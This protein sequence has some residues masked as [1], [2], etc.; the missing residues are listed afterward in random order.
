MTG[1]V[2]GTNT[3]GKLYQELE[4]ESL[5]NRRKL[6]SLSLFYKI[7]KHHTPLFLQNLVSK[8]F[9][10]FYSLRNTD[11]I[12]LFR[13]KHGFFK[14]SFFPSTIIEWNNLDYHVRNAPSISVFK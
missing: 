5:Q 14:S 10:S 1:A 8:K 12:S 11:E 2:R 6:R 9:Q 13:T 7:Y 3:T 4:L